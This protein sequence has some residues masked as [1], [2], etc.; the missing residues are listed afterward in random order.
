MQADCKVQTM[1]FKYA[2]VTTL[3][4]LYLEDFYARN[5]HVAALPYDVHRDALLADAH[6]T[7][8]HY[9]RNFTRLGVEAREFLP[10]AEPLQRAWAREHD[11]PLTDDDLIMAQLRD[12]APD[13]VFLHVSYPLYEKLVPRVRAEVPSAR[14]VHGYL[15]VGFE[16][17]WLP[18]FRGLD[19]MISNDPGL[20]LQLEQGGVK[21]HHVYP[22]FEQSL[23]ER[24]GPV[25]EPD[26]DVLFLGGIVVSDGYHV[27][28]KRFLERLLELGVNLTVHSR[29]VVKKE[30]LAAALEA[31]IRPP[32]YGLAMYRALARARIV[33]NIHLDNVG[34]CASNF[35]LFEAT[36]AGT[37]L[38][39]DRQLN[40]HQLF[41]P[42][43]EVAT[44]ATAEQCAARVEQ[45]LSNDAE[46]RAI[47]EA[48]HQRTLRDH[49]I[50]Q[51]AEIW[52]DIITK[53]L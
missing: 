37:C 19:F 11:S 17:P 44:F 46:R 5:P 7:A 48:G 20:A 24:I 45:L 36:G 34:E 18:A 47:A 38:L 52:L 29:P 40:L 50:A 31:S 8:D 28:R 4:P 42:E 49:R 32:I 27:R 33:L 30:P 53:A 35:R 10:S 51:R 9:S 1:S 26:V 23:T 13:V 21:A 3:S 16:E 14:V 6:A 15:G 2:K 12:F 41:V 22:G 43:K 39:T 25:G